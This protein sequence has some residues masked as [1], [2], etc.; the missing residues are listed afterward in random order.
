MNKSSH[1]KFDTARAEEYARQARIGLAGYD[2][3]HE[4]SACVLAAA[5]PQRKDARVLVVGAG[6]TGGE[7]IAAARLEPGWTFVAVDPSAPML[8]LA[9]AQIDAAGLGAR[10]TFIDG[11]LSAVPPEATFDAVLMIGVLHHVADDAGK[12]ALLRDIAQRLRSGASLILAG[13]YRHYASEPLL[14]AA[15]ANRWRLCGADDSEVQEKLDKIMRGAAP[16]ESEEKV[17]DLLAEAGFE[18]PERFFSSLFWGAWH[19]R[20]ED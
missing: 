18:T 8:D 7:V 15:W 4:L 14:L 1:L 11:D 2:A 12:K 10:V 16:P 3:C 19:T 13:N 9:R 20:R 6:G 17:A 5:L